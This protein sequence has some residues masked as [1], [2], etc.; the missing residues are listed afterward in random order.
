MSTDLVPGGLED[1]LGL[2]SVQV[3]ANAAGTQQVERERVDAGELDAVRDI[4][5]HPLHELL[6]DRPAA[7][8]RAS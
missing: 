6:H 7:C 8:E 2:A 3:H 1:V 4:R 5:S